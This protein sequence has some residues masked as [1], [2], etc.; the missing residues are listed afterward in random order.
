MFGSG[1][2]LS[3]SMSV[4]ADV[5]AT[6]SHA[7]RTNMLMLLEA[8]T[9]G[10]SMVGPLIGAKLANVFTLRAVFGFAAILNVVALLV[11]MAG[12]TES[13]NSNQRVRFT[14][15]RANPVGQLYPLVAHKTMVKF[16]IILV[17][18]K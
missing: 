15:Q 17:R 13:L 5:S 1:A 11:L 12:Y 14:W 18:K 2:F 4:M 6:L 10:G 8:A 9:W 16:A 3:V 7:G